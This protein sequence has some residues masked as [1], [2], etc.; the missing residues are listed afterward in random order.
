MAPNLG[1]RF[2]SSHWGVLTPRGSFIS[3][4][5]DKPEW[6]RKVF[7]DA[8]VAKWR[9]EAMNMPRV[10]DDDVYMSERMFENVGFPTPRCPLTPARAKLDKQVHPGASG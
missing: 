10:D 6:D 5:S 9:E 2:L 3:T 8:I 4:I 7:D 1:S